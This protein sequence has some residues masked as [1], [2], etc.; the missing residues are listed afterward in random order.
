MNLIVNLRRRIGLAVAALAL[1]AVAMSPAPRRSATQ[2][3]ASRCGRRAAPT[4]AAQDTL[5]RQEPEQRQLRRREPFARAGLEQRTSGTRSFA[6]LGRPGRPRRARRL[7]R[8]VYGI[9][10]ANGLPEG[11]R[12]HRPVSVRART[13]SACPGSAP[14]RRKATRRS[15]TS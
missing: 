5:R 4:R 7:A 6:I 1:A 10:P 14:A 12:R 8:V 13:R 2:A 11:A 15:T 9:A 3:S